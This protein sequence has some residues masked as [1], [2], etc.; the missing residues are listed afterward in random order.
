[1]KN[2]ETVRFNKISELTSLLTRINL[3]DESVSYFI[4]VGW[5]NVSISELTLSRVSEILLEPEIYISMI[6]QDAKGQVRWNN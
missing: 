6:R 4:Y 3:F 1:M 2:L 5:I